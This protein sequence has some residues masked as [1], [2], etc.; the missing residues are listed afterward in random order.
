MVPHPFNFP[1]VLGSTVPFLLSSSS[2]QVPFSSLF[3]VGGLSGRL[4]GILVNI[5]EV[6]LDFLVQSFSVRP[7]QL[8]LLLVNEF[9]DS[10]LI[11]VSLQ[12]SR[13]SEFEFSGVTLSFWDSAFVQDLY[14]RLFKEQSSLLI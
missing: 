1:G 12:S 10:L 9:R 5:V 2:I 7:V 8:A 14:S 13:Q 4:V 11:V 6:K 3:P